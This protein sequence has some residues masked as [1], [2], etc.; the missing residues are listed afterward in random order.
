[1]IATRQ[2]YSAVNSV[3]FHKVK[4]DQV[5]TTQCIRQ[6]TDPTLTCTAYTSDSQAPFWQSKV[7]GVPKFRIGEASLMSGNFY[8][9]SGDTLYRFFVGEPPN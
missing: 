9:A 6:A 8:V 4:D 5:I 3:T 7:N 2:S 1:V